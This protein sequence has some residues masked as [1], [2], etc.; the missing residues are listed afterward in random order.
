MFLRKLL[1]MI[2]PLMLCAA[3][4][5]GMPLIAGLGFFTQVLR[6]V[7][8]GAALS[9]ILPLCGASRRRETF[10]KLLWVP[11]II[12]LVV[13]LYQYLTNAG[14]LR[15]PALTFLATSQPNTVLIESAM[16]AYLMGHLL[17]WK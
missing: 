14:M 17:R 16:M 11:A 1:V 15:I 8:L 4:C 9:L 7:V 6:G 12:L 10:G 3:L 2:L 5:L 13:L